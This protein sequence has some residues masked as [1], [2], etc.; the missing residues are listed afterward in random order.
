[1]SDDKPTPPTA[2]PKAALQARVGYRLI[3]LGEMLMSTA[4]DALAPLGVRPR[5]FNVLAT[6]AADASLSQQ[7]LSRLLGIDPNVMVGVVDDLERLGFATR[8]RNPLDRRRH[9]IELTPT[10][11][12]V[13][14]GGAALLD[15]A[16]AKVFGLLSAK[17]RA[18][19]YDAAGRLLDE[20]GPM[21]HKA[22]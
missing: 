13:V 21:V 4:E 10:G 11:R 5:H 15:A 22:P 8:V 2:G 20:H 16:E 17:E 6:L 3:K 7:D 9:I 14:K 19:L 1:V 18:T 12:G